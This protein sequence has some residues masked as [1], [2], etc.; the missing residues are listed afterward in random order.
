VRW[1]EISA[2]LGI[3][4]PFE[5]PNVHIDFLNI[6]EEGH[7]PP[8]AFLVLATVFSPETLRKVGIVSEL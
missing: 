4:V 3:C 7:E 6:G 2:S 5:V 8:Q 1:A